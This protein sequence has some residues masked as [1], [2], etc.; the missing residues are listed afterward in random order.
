ME[1]DIIE[2]KNVVKNKIFRIG[3]R[4]SKKRKNFLIKTVRKSRFLRRNPSNYKKIQ[5]NQNSITFLNED[6]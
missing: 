5:I 6:S 4:A 1:L 3:N 2:N